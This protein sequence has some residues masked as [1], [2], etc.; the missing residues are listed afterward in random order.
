M[1][2]NFFGIS[3]EESCES[4]EYTENDMNPIVKKFLLEFC[5]NFFCTKTPSIQ[6]FISFY[7]LLFHDSYQLKEEIFSPKCNI[8]KKAYDEDNDF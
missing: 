8:K 4:Q 1:K 3:P 6:E 7:H 5:E 2:T